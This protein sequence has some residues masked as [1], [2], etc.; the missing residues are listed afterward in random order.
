MQYKEGNVREIV[1]AVAVGT[2]ATTAS[3]KKYGS[4]EEYWGSGM[5]SWSLTLSCSIL[6][7]GLSHT[8]P[9][10]SGSA[11]VLAAQWSGAF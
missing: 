3:K 7:F 8:V 6:S 1:Q 9:H 5:L 11:S 2:L 10:A 4:P